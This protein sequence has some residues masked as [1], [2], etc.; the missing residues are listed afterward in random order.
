MSPESQN[1]DA[2]QTA[3]AESEERRLE[4][5]FKLE[6]LVKEVEQLR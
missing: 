3:L 1:V 5:E 6:D 2:L 4:A